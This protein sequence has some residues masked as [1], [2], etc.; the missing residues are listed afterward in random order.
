MKLKEP[1]ARLKPSEM[2]MA[3]VS[4]SKSKKT[5]KKSTSAKGG[6]MKLN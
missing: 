2:S 5:V 4:K 3:Q 6:K 1:I